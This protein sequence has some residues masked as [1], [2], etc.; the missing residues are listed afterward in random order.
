M[1]PKEKRDLLLRDRPHVRRCD[2]TN[3]KDVGILWADYQRGNFKAP[4][5]LSKE[6]FAEAVKDIALFCEQIWFVEDNTRAFQ[7]GRGPVSLVSVRTDGW[8]Y[9]P[10]AHHF[11]W[12]SKRNKARSVVA[13]LQMMR[14]DKEVG[15]CVVFG[16]EDEKV[17]LDA[18][19]DYGV[20]YASGKV[21]H[22]LPEGTAYIYSIKGKRELA[23]PPRLEG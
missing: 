5:G 7:S 16:G 6:Q 8:K 15:A 17:F 18:L 3:L 21:Q 2:L 1:S 22:G 11:S 4:P 13:F 12:A 10:R 14:Y 19:R 23:R 20:L 9:E